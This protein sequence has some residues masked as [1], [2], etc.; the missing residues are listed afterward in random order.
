MHLELQDFMRQ[1]SQMMQWG[2]YVICGV[3]VCL[4]IREIYLLINFVSR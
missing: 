4:S 1:D 2:E 3:L